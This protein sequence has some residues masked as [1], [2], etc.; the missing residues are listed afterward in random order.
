MLNIITRLLKRI[1][2]FLLPDSDRLRFL[3]NR[4]KLDT[5]SRKYLKVCPIFKDRTRMYDYLNKEVIKNNPINYLEFGVWEGESIQY[6]SNLNTNTESK[7]TGF[8]TF[9]GLPEDWKGLT[10]TVA[11][12]TFSTHGALPEIDDNRV[13]FVKGMFQDTLPNFLSA[14]SRLGQLV[15]HNDSDLYSST[16][17]VLTYANDYIE[18]GTIIIFD[19]FYDVMHE[20]RALEDYC[21]AYGRE[22][23]VVAATRRVGQI[24]IKIK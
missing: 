22:Y 6:F 5:W 11:R 10:R 15:I 23:E 12:Q 21:N 9:E 13:S 20:F 19:E 1:V 24:A 16:L 18:S 8:D 14:N 7:F 4:P 2:L 17:Y 3:F